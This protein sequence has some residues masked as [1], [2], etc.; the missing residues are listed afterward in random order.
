MGVNDINKR[1]RN[2]PTLHLNPVSPSFKSV[3]VFGNENYM[4]CCIK[5][6]TKSAFFFAFVQ[7]KIHT[8]TLT[9]PSFELF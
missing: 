6:K 3:E 4:Q 7:L 1:S 2:Y 9:Y 5:L 8:L